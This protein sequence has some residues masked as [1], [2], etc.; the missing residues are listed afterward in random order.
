M[1]PA[2]DIKINSAFL[3]PRARQGQVGK[4]KICLTFEANICPKMPYKA[5]K[6]GEYFKLARCS[7]SSLWMFFA[8][9]VPISVVLMKKLFLFLKIRESNYFK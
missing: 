2:L 9:L 7:G 3:Y 6:R 5:K 4:I 8:Y 1:G